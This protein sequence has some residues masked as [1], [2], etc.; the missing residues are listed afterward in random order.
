MAIWIIFGPF[1]IFFP[2]FGMLYQE[3]SVN[4]DPNEFFCTGIMSHA[5]SLLTMTC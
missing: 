1:G 3:K 2:G 4:H 5:L